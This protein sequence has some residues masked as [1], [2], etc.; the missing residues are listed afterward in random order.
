MRHVIIGGDGFLGRQLAH[1]LVSRGEEVVICGLTKSAL[2]IYDKVPFIH[3]DITDPS[4]R[5]LGETSLPSSSFRMMDLL[6]FSR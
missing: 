5:F 4:W 2:D 1:E 6:A 3:M